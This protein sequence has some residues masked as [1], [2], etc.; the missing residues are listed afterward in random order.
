MMYVIAV[1]CCIYFYA[2]LGYL[3]FKSLRKSR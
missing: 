3:I 2:T 1:G